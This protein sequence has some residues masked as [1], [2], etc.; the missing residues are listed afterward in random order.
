MNFRRVKNLKRGGSLDKLLIVD[1][2]NLLFQMFFGMPSRI[3]NKDGKAIHGVLGFVGALIKIIKMTVPTHIVVLFDGEH[4]NDRTELLAEYKAN[5][6]D[7]SQVPYNESPF[8]QLHD[9]YKALD[10][11]EIKHTEVAEFEADDVIASYALTYGQH[12][13]I[14]ISSFDSDFFQLI[15]DNVSVL[16]YRGDKTL[17]CG[18]EY[19]KEKY[20]ILPSQYADFKSLTGDNADN[21]KGA[22]KIGK[23]TAAAQLNQFGSLLEILNSTDKI[24]KPSIK[25]SIIKNNER[26][27]NNYKLIKLDNKADL[28]FELKKLIYSYN[29]ITTNEV[30]KGVG[31][32]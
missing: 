16:R 10:F 7:Y 12:M 32:R 21:I 8:S 11:M 25:E 17:I 22:D 9:V 18:I 3:I 23:I 2:L 30:L 20:G 19:I 15:S 14:I 24:N 29:G 13:Q 31:L 4:E 26:L 5:R 6:I 27:R 28:P 1:G